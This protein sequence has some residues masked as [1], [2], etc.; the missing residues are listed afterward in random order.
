MLIKYVTTW[1][2]LALTYQAADV[3]GNHYLDSIECF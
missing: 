3:D 2:E 1:N